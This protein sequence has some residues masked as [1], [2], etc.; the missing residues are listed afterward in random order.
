MFL[1]EVP[2]VAKLQI[3]AANLPEL[4]LIFPQAPTSNF[5]EFLIVGL[6]TLIA[7]TVLYCVGLPLTTPTHFSE[8]SLSL[9]TV[10]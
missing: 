10:L 7:D 6:A 3:V 2:G 8:I 5:Q 1:R 9:E 4:Q